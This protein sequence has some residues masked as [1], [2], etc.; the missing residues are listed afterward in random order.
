[1]DT[2]EWDMDLIWKVCPVY[3][4]EEICRIRL[5]AR[6]TSDFLA[7]N[8]EDSGVFSVKSAYRLAEE[9]KNRDRPAASSS[10]SET[11]NRSI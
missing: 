3:D 10:S 4:A 2:N 8:H 5:P 6:K 7:W 11:S 1:M 9:I